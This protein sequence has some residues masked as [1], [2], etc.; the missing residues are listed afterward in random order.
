M[1]ASLFQQLVDNWYDA[2][3]RFALSLSRNGDE[4]MDLTQQ[5][6]ARWAEKGHGLRDASKA[7]SWLFTVLYREFLNAKRHQNREGTSADEKFF[8]DIPA[9]ERSAQSAAEGHNAMEALQQVDAVF[10]APL[11][12]FY[13]ESH[14][15]QEIAEILEVPIGTVMSRISRGKEQLRRILQ[16]RQADRPGKVIPLRPAKE[17]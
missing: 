9:E 14:S 4:A 11:V 17:N 7:K 1:D 3:Y 16:T 10:R 13:L 12:L 6:F 5:T 2:L 8:D 15:Y